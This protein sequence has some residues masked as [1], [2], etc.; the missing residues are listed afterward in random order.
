MGSLSPDF[1]TVL[2]NEGSVHR[3]GMQYFCYTIQLVSYY[4]TKLPT[5][6]LS[7]S[8]IQLA[9][10][11]Q[12]VVYPG[13]DAI[14]MAMSEALYC[15]RNEEDIEDEEEEGGIQRPFLSR[16]ELV[17]VFTATPPMNFLS[18]LDLWGTL[19]S[20]EKGK[21]IGDTMIRIPYF[22]LIYL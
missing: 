7:F 3:D 22:Y 9:N 15:V 16:F 11:L 20:V 12:E 2:A 17:K 1:F 18:W 8:L 13:E 4:Q 10:C 21:K 14:D 6:H 19:P 5:Y